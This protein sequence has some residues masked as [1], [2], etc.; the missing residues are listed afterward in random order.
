LAAQSLAQ[1]TGDSSLATLTLS[2]S[3]FERW[4]FGKVTPQNDARRVLAHLFKRPVPQ[5][6]AEVPAPTEP[7]YL[8]RGLVDA[9]APNTELRADPGA[10]LHWMER[11]A[12]MAARR[13]MEFA[14]GAE[15]NEVGQQTLDYLQ[16][17]V[18]RIAEVHLRVPV[19]TILDDLAYI[20][21]AT[22]RLLE[23][24][25]AKPSQVRDLYLLASL[26]SGMLSKASHDLGDSQ[27]A[28]MQARTAAVCAD[29]AEHQTMRAWVRGLQSAI[30][31]WAERPEDALHYARQGVA[32]GSNLRGSVMVWLAV[33]EARAAALLGDAETVHAANCRAEELRERTLADDLD[34]LGGNF[35]FPQIRQNYFSVE[36]NVMLGDSNA[37]LV[38]RAEEAVRGFSDT[39]DPHWAFGSEA[40]AQSNLALARLHMGDLEGAAEAVHPVL[41]LP[42]SH[43]IAGI[44]GSVQRVQASLMH[45]PHRDAITARELREEIAAFSSRRALA[46]PR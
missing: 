3:T 43:R 41:D 2:E 46:L 7:A 11:H 17:E 38:R 5:L 21:D 4:Y 15:R 25:R 34:A 27:S 32:I 28:V 35:H 10:A 13:A 20:Q 29:Q 44:I 39:N 40:G 31:Y 42:P 45:G 6:L 24:G 30:S 18:R 23:S 12:A 16:H 22:F 33:Q 9:G 14:M 37:N 26:Q 36:A 1:E 8:G 19:G